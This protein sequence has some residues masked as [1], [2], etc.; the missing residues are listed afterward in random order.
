ML[1]NIVTIHLKDFEGLRRTLGS[2]RSM[3]DV[4]DVRWIVV[5][6]GSSR[7]TADDDVLL[8]EVAA[9]ADAYISEPDNGIYHAMNKGTAKAL[10]GYLLYLNAGDELH[11]EF[12]WITLA[13]HVEDTTPEMIWGLCHERYSDGTLVRVH[14]R[15]PALAWYGMPVNHQ[16]VLFRRD[17]VGDQPYDTSLRILADY[18][19]VSRLLKSGGRVY[20]TGMPIAIFHRGGRNAQEFN[21]TMREEER[22]RVQY[23]G[24]PRLVSH[25][26]G[27]FKTFN[28]WLGKSPAIRRV[29]RRWV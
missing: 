26:I 13:R 21:A 11:P 10:N 20:R 1:L 4:P 9:L 15:S 18:D 3:L 23:Y 25:L 28:A 29:L 7:V 6:G 14:N 17:S 8:G 27:R 2:L 5:D 16:N 22:L 19:L 12:D 24:V